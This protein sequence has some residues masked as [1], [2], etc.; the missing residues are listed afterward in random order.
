MESETEILHVVIRGRVQGVGFRYATC[1][2][3]RELRLRGWVRNLPGGE[4][5]A[6]FHGPRETLETAL[7]WCRQGPRVAHVT[8]VDIEWRPEDAPCDAFTIQ[9]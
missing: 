7:A 1:D 4:V 6:E 9:R 8:Q 2:M 3:A 5:E